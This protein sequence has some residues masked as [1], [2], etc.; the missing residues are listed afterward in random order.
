MPSNKKDLQNAHNL[1]HLLIVQGIITLVF[2]VV[3]FFWPK[4]S[5]SVFI[6]LFSMML[7]A[8][9]GVSILHA[10][11]LDDKQS[12]APFLIEGIIALGIGIFTFVNPQ[13]SGSMIVFLLAVWAFLTGIFKMAFSLAFPKLFDNQLLVFV[14]GIV[15]MLLGLFLFRNPQEGILGLTSLI[16]FFA[17]IAGVLK[18]VASFGVRRLIKDLK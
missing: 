6:T 10:F 5:V 13:I 8:I 7:L 9:G 16:G 1:A 12:K 3:L 11:Q 18:I 4:V 17:I 14:T 2:G 15:Y